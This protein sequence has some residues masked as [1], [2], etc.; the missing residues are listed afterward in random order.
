MSE[1]TSPLAGIRVLDLTRVLAG[2]YCTMTLGDL[3]AEIIKVERPGSGDDTRAWG[4]PWAETESAYYLSANRN[5]RSITL[6]IKHPEAQQIIRDLAAKSDIVVENFKIG[7]LE[8]LSLGYEDLSSLN[9]GLI[10]ATISGYGP[11]GPLADKPGYDFVA[12]GEGGIMSITGEPD[13]EPMKVGVAIVDITTG[14]NTAIAILAALH[15]RSTSGLGQKID[16][17]LYSSAIGWLANVGSNYLISGKPS[18]RYGNAHANIVPYQIFQT[19]DAYITIGAGTDRQFR[20]LCKIIDRID[21]AED[22]RFRSNSLRVKH[23]EELIPILEEAFLT[24]DAEYWIDQ[25]YKATIPSGPINTVDE[26]YN[27]PQTQS[28]GMVVEVPHPTA[29]C[30]KLTGIPFRLSRTP[31]TVSKAPPLLGEDTSS[32]LGE[33]LGIHEDKIEQLREDGAI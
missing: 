15:E 18:G 31:A 30:I 12:Q 27:H 33:I 8:K 6:N 25:C 26:V 22:P 32:I 20:D 10:W 5:K 29:G 14:M 11:D 17:S 28:Q 2:P 4:P 7:T 16:T 21:V 13:G 9:P 23:R 24:Q 1:P 19:R 3:G